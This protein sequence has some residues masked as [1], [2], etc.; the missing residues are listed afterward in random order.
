MYTFGEE[1][2]EPAAVAEMVAQTA[3]SEPITVPESVA[4]VPD[5]T[6][7]KNEV[8]L[9]HKLDTLGHD[10]RA[11]FRPLLNYLANLIGR[12]TKSLKTWTAIGKSID[13]S[14][15][16]DDARIKLKH[17]HKLFAEKV[18]PQPVNLAYAFIPLIAF[19]LI[20]GYVS[21]KMH[22]R[23]IEGLLKK[24]SQKRRE[25]QQARKR[26]RKASKKSLP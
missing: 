22:E 23:R 24:K 13:E 12:Q 16:S 10:M 4:V 19:W 18:I 9:E 7:L 15:L 25:E 11:T 2:L 8:V 21:G 17:R 14:D 26:A 1:K 20:K 6:L 3:E 5:E